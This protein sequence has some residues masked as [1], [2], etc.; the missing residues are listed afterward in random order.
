MDYLAFSVHKSVSDL[1]S[2]WKSVELRKPVIYQYRYPRDRVWI[3]SLGTIF[4]FISLRRVDQFQVWGVFLVDIIITILSTTA[5][6][7]TLAEGWGDLAVL[8]P[9]D[10]PYTA[11]PFL[12]GLGKL[13]GFRAIHVLI[14]FL[15]ASAVHFFFC[16]RIWRL[17]RSYVIPVLI[18]IVSSTHFAPKSALFI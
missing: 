1:M 16:W 17:R 10:R 11:L 18:M 14:R 4:I 3:K 7:N 6:W 13:F 5:L 9:L 8:L 12:S 2:Q 15:V